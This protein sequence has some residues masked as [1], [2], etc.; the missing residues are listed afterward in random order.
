MP[1]RTVRWFFAG[2]PVRGFW[3]G[4]RGRSRPHWASVKSLDFMK[5][6]VGRQRVCGHALAKP[7]TCWGVIGG[8]MHG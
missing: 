1:V 4:S 3:G 2:R 8:P 5:R 6:I 7:R